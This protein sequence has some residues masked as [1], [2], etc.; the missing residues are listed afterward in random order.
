MEL[1]CKHCRC[2]E[3]AGVLDVDDDVTLHDGEHWQRHLRGVGGVVHCRRGLWLE[4][5]DGVLGIRAVD[6]LHHGCTAVQLVKARQ[7]REDDLPQHQGL[8]R[9][10]R[11]CLWLRYY[12]SHVRHVPSLGRDADAPVVGGT[13]CCEEVHCVER[14]GEESAE[15]EIG[16]NDSACPALAR[17]AVHH[18]HVLVVFREES[19]DL[20]AERQ[21][22]AQWR[23]SVVRPPTCM[24]FVELA[25]VVLSLSEV[26]HAIV[27]LVVG[28]EHAGNL[29]HAV[30]VRA[31]HAPLCRETHGYDPVGDV[32]EVQVECAI[33]EPVLVAAHFRAQR[34]R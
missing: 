33:S 5:S 21:E 22:V 10:V 1:Y 16:G 3:Q 7:A 6:D 4:N 20:L 29:L 24:R 14:G 23:S 31:L 8:R 18:H 27:P 11:I 34:V 2:S 32:G 25:C 17:Q 13:S 12:A 30:P 28:V 15:E 26:E 19:V 9:V